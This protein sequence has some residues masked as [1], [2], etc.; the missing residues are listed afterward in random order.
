MSDACLVF[1][2]TF[3]GWSVRC[4]SHEPRP[5]LNRCRCKY[6]SNSHSVLETSI[7]VNERLPPSQ[8][9]RRRKHRDSPGQPVYAPSGRGLNVGTHFGLGSSESLKVVDLVG[10][11]PI[12][13][14]TSTSFPLIAEGTRQMRQQAQLPPKGSSHKEWLN[15]GAP[16]YADALKLL[17]SS[18]PDRRRKDPCDCQ[19]RDR[20][21]DS[22][23]GSWR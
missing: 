11:I 14:W 4:S 8:E 22:V 23:I 5:A 16:S 21:R 13:E 19:V 6:P 2:T 17:V 7:L 9:M 1:P 12:M 3:C 20:G 18:H 10:Y 15:N